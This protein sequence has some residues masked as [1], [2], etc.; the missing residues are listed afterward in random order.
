[1]LWLQVLL[2]VLLSPGVILTLPPV[3]SNIFFSG[4]TSVT[5]VLVH[6]VV[7]TL[8]YQ[9]ALKAITDYKLDGFQACAPAGQMVTG[10]AECCTGAMNANKV[11]VCR[12]AGN[13][14]GN[15]RE[16]CSGQLNSAGQC[17]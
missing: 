14:P 13:T 11:C 1:M 2:F 8:V 10:A 5:A 3:G 9:C 12:T 16:C 4:K 15:V 7:F 6:A 17:S